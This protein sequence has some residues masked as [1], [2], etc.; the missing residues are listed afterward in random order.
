MDP[1]RYPRLEFDMVGKDEGSLKAMYS[2]L[3]ERIE[4]ERQ[5]IVQL[6][7]QC[8][9][10]NTLLSEAGAALSTIVEKLRSAEARISA[11]ARTPEDGNPLSGRD[12]PAR[13]DSVSD[14]IAAALKSYGV[15]EVHLSSE[16]IPLRLSNFYHL[17][18]FGRWTGPGLLSSFGI[19]LQKLLAAG[20]TSIEIDF[21]LSLIGPVQGGVRFFTGSQLEPLP[22]DAVSWTAHP[23]ARL[24]LSGSGATGDLHLLTPSTRQPL[25][26]VRHL[27]VAVGAIRFLA[28]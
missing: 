19:D 11:E 14:I 22:A 20:L 6:A 10:D 12:R 3:A 25:P 7:A 2:N 17:E 26:D 18:A 15:C 23:T 24:N 5:Y 4:I 16:A 13:H 9:G 8:A 21:P 28:G 27:G 1:L